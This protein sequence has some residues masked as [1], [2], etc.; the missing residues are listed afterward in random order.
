MVW[1]KIYKAL[2]VFFFLLYLTFLLLS[3]FTL[4]FPIINLINTKLLF[5]PAVVKVLLV[6]FAIILIIMLDFYSLALLLNW[7]LIFLSFF[8]YF[9]INKVEVNWWLLGYIGLTAIFIGLIYFKPINFNFLL[10]YCPLPIGCMEVVKYFSLMFI[11]AFIT[12]HIITL[13]DKPKAISFKSLLFSIVWFAALL[14]FFFS[15]H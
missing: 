1:H 4:T 3:L 14:Y 7:Q 6:I 2:N 15:L 13:L 9:R 11:P 12:Y 10:T 8:K 5:L